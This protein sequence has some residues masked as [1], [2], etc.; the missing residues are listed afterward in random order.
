MTRAAPIRAV[1]GLIAV[2]L[3]LTGCAAS[4]PTAAPAQA[5]IPGAV[6]DALVLAEMDRQ[7]IPGLA[8]AVLRDGQPVLSKGY[9]QATIAPMT[10]VTDQTVFSIGSLSK[11]FLAAAIMLLV[12]D[13]KIELDEPIR[14]YL[15]DAPDSWRAI[16]LRNLMNHSSGLIREGPGFRPD[17]IQP[18]IDVIRSAYAAPLSYPTGE[19]FEYS[20]LG[21]FVIAE[22]ISRRS[23]K[24]WPDFV[25]TRLFAPAGMTQADLTSTERPIP[26]RALG[27]EWRNDANQ[28]AVSMA[29]LRPSG[30]FIASLADMI[31]WEQA[32]NR[33]TVV[34]SGSLRQ[35]WAASRFNDGTEGAYGFG[36]RLE[37][38]DGHFEVG[39]G[40]S[41]PGF[42][43][44]YA[45][46]PN[47]RLSVIVLT[48]EGDDDPRIIARQV[49]AHY[50]N[51]Q[52]N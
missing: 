27:Y 40:G 44:Y 18:D 52:S 19:R 6:I 37:T 28:K 46:Y 21:Y 29:A 43:A 7:H 42:R 50:L 34:S 20:N 22:I 26:D 17:R 10:T 51:R 45:R 14:T 49:A 36:W 1:V 15:P 39:H 16:T 8:L 24:A 13:G 3:V 47:D 5:Q 41:L 4:A 32:L 31:R 38:T 23:G 48:N 33:G 9:G 25:K 2:L 11:Q 12:E 35:M 30:A